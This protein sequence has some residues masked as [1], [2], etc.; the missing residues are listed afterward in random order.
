MAQN[1]AAAAIK[2]LKTLI[3]AAATDASTRVYVGVA[4]QSAVYPM[5]VMDIVSSE[6]TESQDSGSDVSR[7]RIQVDMWAKD[8]AL[9]SGFETATELDNDV[10]GAISRIRAASDSSF[11]DGVQEVNFLTDYMPE[12]DVYR[13]SRDYMVRVK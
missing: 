6:E 11:V 4:P 8:T 10:R 12:I 5:I 3:E 9:E 13:V 2:H 1:R 7:F